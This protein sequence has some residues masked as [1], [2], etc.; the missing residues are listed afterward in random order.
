[1]QLESNETILEALDS[2]PIGGGSEYSESAG[3]LHPSEA[4]IEVSTAEG[5]VDALN[6]SSEIIAIANNAVIDLTGYEMLDLGSKTLVSYRG[7]NGREGALLYTNSR[8]YYGSRPYTLFYSFGSPR[9]TGIR[10]RGAHYDE[11]FTR[12][13]YS[14]HLARGIMLRGP[15]GE[16]DNCEIWGWTWNAVHLKGYGEDTITNAAV[17]HN[18]IHKSYQLGYG[19][20]I[21][22]WRGFGEIHH[23]YF[24]E[25]RRVVAGYG[26]WNSGFIV[27]SNVFGPRQNSHQV[28]M[29]C[30]EENDANRRVGDDQ[31]HPDYDLRAGGRMV[32]R[33]NTF[34]SDTSTN[35]GGMNSIAIRGVP[36]NGVWIENNRFTHSQRPPYNSGND[37]EGFT[38]RQVNLN[39]SNWEPIPQDDEGYTLNWNDST[40]QFDA[41]NTPWR[42]GFGA[43]INLDDPEADGRVITIISQGPRTDYRFTTTGDVEK[44]TAYGA[45]IDPGDRIRDSTV[46]GAVAGGTDSFAYYGEITSFNA[47]GPAEVRIN[48]QEV[49][50]EEL[51]EN[52]ITI[53]SQGS[54]ASYTISVESDAEKSAQY[55]ASVDPGDNIV[56]Y[57]DENLDTIITGRVKGGSDSF[58]F[59]GPVTSFSV[60]GEAEVL[61]NGTLVNSAEFGE[62]VITISGRGPRADYELEFTG[63]VEKSTAYGASVDS[64]DRIVDSEI[65]GAVSSGSDSFIF[66]GQIT[67]FTS[68]S[69]VDILFNGQ[70][71]GMWF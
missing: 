18:H 46:V 62:Q 66:E 25:T 28:D 37:P 64:G 40:N 60:S 5:L 51:G 19:Y 57:D 3:K 59:E 50:P 42:P 16:I 52:V 21:S 10:I 48:G 11:E 9:I 4:D 69:P 36:W 38:W 63:N 17:H 68:N 7:W 24:D 67:D 6:G 41:T 27:E 13:D 2:S 53:R 71:T 15:G 26:W 23:N 54:L 47:E 32:I 34:T 56:R 31:N 30:L 22:I 65:R 33:N 12:W 61:I 29:H 43:P 39:L 44:S 35:G 58:V 8:G 14:E 45:S 55:G 70:P 20:G 1:M 49:N